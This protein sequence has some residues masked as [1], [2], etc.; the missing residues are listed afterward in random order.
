MVRENKYLGSKGCARN[1]LRV[2]KTQRYKATS[3]L[4]PP[5]VQALPVMEG[6]GLP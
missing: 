3:A 5:H 1:Q 6:G 2:K 4:V